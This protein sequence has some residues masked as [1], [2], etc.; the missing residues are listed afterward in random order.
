MACVLI[1]DIA[2]STWNKAQLQLESCYRHRYIY[3]HKRDKDDLKD[4]ECLWQSC[5]IPTAFQ[6]CGLTFIYVS[7]YNIQFYSGNER[8]APVYLE[9]WVSNGAEQNSHLMFECFQTG[10]D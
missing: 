3:S 6:N 5:W 7:C 8:L 2:T 10:R 1:T 4:T 9:I